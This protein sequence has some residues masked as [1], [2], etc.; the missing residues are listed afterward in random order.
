MENLRVSTIT[1]VAEL[2]TPIDLEL[3]F[4]NIEIND[5]I[6]YIEKGDLNKGDPNKNKRKSRKTKKNTVFFNQATIHFYLDKIINV[7]LFNNGK[8][9]MTGLKKENQGENVIK[10]LIDIIQSIDMKNDHK[11]FLKSHEKYEYENYRIALINSDF[12]YKKS[13]NRDKLQEVMISMDMFSSYEPCIYPGVNIK[14]FYNI[15]NEGCKGVCNCERKCNG[16]GNGIDT[17]RRVTIA[18]FNSGKI[19]ITGAMNRDQLVEC[20]NFIN[21]VI[22]KNLQIAGK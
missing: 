9:Q 13:I 15:K 21:E 22:D 6:K 19:I 12:D 14:Y 4:K 17:C 20:Y 3:L 7:K 8:I 1:S 2:N 16:K 11:I 10:E 5:K 18:V